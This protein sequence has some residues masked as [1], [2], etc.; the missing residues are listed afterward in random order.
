MAAGL[1]KAYGLS[2]LRV[3]RGVAIDDPQKDACVKQ[4]SHQS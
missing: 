1:Q 2:D 4:I 3:L